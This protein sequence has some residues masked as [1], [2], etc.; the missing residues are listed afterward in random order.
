MLVMF[1]IDGTS[2]SFVFLNAYDPI[3]V[4]ESGSVMSAKLVHP[5]K[6]ES[7]TFCSP[8]GSVT[9]F[10]DSQFLNSPSGS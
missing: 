3:S 5:S 9:F 10:R 6:S 1:S 8:A 2:D 7:E 4:T